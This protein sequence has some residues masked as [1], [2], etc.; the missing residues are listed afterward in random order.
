M[1]S[2]IW[3]PKQVEVH[4]TLAA[5]DPDL[6]LL[7]AWRNGD[8]KAASDLIARHYETI[9]RQI[10]TKVPE[11]EIDD[12][13]QRVI[14]ALLEG[15]EK[16]RG[17]AKFKSYAMRITRNVI[18]GFYRRR[19]PTTPLDVL[20]VS[21][22]D[23]GVGPSTLLDDQDHKSQRLLLEALRSIAIDDQFVLE[24]HYWEKMS[25]PTLAQVYECSEP[26]IR[27]RLRRAKERLRAQITVI[28]EERR[29]LAD[30]LTDLD[31]WALKL[32]EA[33]AVRLRRPPQV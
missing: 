30:T 8:K 2:T 11:S 21:V 5:V 19:R 24:L 12:L 1:T 4:G 3:P 16:F 7:E 17:D 33:L 28:A 27:G 25:G 15:R 32:R 9:R 31:S 13:V 14:V 29:E 10:A 18:A 22:V 23:H 6:D 20:E 26:A